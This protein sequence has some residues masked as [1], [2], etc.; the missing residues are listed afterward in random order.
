MRSSATPWTLTRYSEVARL[1]ERT[2]VARVRA[3]R[4]LAGSGSQTSTPCVQ[5]IEI[6][7]HALD[8]DEVFGGCA[9]G[10]EDERGAREGVAA[11]CGKRFPDLDTVRADDRDRQPRP[12]R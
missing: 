9:T 10:R 3:L 1:G 5:T 2:S 12:G 11:P 6:V 8:V 4:R 7:S